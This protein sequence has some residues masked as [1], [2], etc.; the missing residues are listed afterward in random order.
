LTDIRSL[1]YGKLS[2]DRN[3]FAEVEIPVVPKE[4]S[5]AP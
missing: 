1:I 5:S 2:S 3:V 4:T